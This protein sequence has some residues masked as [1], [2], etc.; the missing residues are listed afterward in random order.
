MQEYNI[1][2]MIKHNKVDILPIKHLYYIKAL[3]PYERY[4]RITHRC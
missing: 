1:L 3:S 4:N 2:H